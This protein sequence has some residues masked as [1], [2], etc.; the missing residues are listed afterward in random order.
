MFGDVWNMRLSTARDAKAT[1]SAQIADTEGQIESL[2]DRIVNA[3]N[4]SVIAAYEARIEKLERQKIILAEQADK[5]I[6]PPGR[7]EEFIEHALAF[8]ASPWDICENGSI[9]LK[10]TVLK[11]ALAEPLRYN[12]ETGYRTTANTFPFKV[13]ADFSTPKCGMVEGA[14]FEPA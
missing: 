4:P 13:L 3:A 7:M 2:L 8:L 1:L 12:R 6:P 5:A 14:G 10:R 9:A 11:L